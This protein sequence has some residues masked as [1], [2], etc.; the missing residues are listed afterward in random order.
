MVLFGPT[1]KN[2]FEIEKNI[3]LKEDVCAS[4]MWLLGSQWHT[5]CALEHQ[6]CQNMQAL[7]AKKVFE[8]VAEAL[9]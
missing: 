3:N 9:K 4:C 8:A 5:K 1:D 7:S 2:Y 6:S